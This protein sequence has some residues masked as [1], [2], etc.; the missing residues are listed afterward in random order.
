V[1]LSSY[2]ELAVRLA[3]TA[4]VADG[5]P[6]SLSTTAACTDALGDCLAGPATRRDLS[7]LSYL[8]DEFAAIFTAAATG[9][10]KAAVARLNALMIQFPIQLELVS[11]D[12]QRWHAHLASHGTVADRFAAGAV[13][14]VSL[15]V[16]LYGVNRLGVCAIASCRRVFIDSSS[17]NSRRYCADHTAARGNVAALR[18]PSQAVPSHVTPAAS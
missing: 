3:N 16:S 4:V 1:N 7:V 9:D 18:A 17:N 12:E 15:T 5:E 6:D 13:I 14:G 2:A 8:R 10:E 11:H